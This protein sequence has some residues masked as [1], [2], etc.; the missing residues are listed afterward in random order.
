MERIKKSETIQDEQ[1][2]STNKNSDRG[3][4][5]VGGRS[6][7]ENGLRLKD[8]KVS[9]ERIKIFESESAFEG[10]DA[11][12]GLKNERSFLIGTKPQR[13]NLVDNG[14]HLFSGQLS[15]TSRRVK[16]IIYVPC[17]NCYFIAFDSHLYRKEIDDKP[18]FL[19]L[20]INC[21]W[22]LGGCFRYSIVHQRLIINK[23]K[24]KISVVNLENRELEIEIEKGVGDNIRDFRLF[25]E[26]EDRVISVTC[27]GYLVL[28]RLNY[29]QMEGSVI[30]DFK[31]EL[32]ED[33]QEQPWSISLCDRNEYA[34]VEMGAIICSR[35][36]ILKV[37]GDTLVKNAVLDQYNQK[38]GCKLASHS[39]GYLGRHILW[40]G[41][42]MDDNGVAQIYDYDTQSGEM[43]ELVDKRVGHGE[44][45]PVKINRL[46]DKF[47]Y[48]GERGQVMSLSIGN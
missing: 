24:K 8:L 43:K 25:G 37:N 28:Y 27:D 17:L 36:M 16:D 13:L 31:L 18:P 15:K 3:A 48:T 12:I 42:S 4:E 19:F 23:D 29:D 20:D 40:V 22:R 44:F 10:D 35:M 21:G 14:V 38:I 26:Q 11:V 5:N 47:Y 41:L 46:G 39:Y 33:R 2:I 6:Q 30:A 32:I 34:L 45:D 7:E 1:D 9:V